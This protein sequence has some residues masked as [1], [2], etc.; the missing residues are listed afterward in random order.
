MPFGI[1]NPF[2]TAVGNECKKAGKVKLTTSLPVHDLPAMSRSSHR[3]STHGKPSALTRSYLPRYWP[4]QRYAVCA[5]RCAPYYLGTPSLSTNVLTEK[6]GPCHHHRSESRLPGLRTLWFRRRRRSPLR[7]LLVR[8][9]RNCHWRRRFRRP[10]RLRA[11][12]LRLHPQ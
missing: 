10:N 1:H 2:P 12:G 11:Y 4:M 8:T 3:S 7:W 6:L 9:L 5:A